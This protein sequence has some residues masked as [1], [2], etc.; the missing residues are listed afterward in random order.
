MCEDIS[1]ADDFD[2]QLGVVSGGVF[3]LIR[4]AETKPM[5][6]D[7]SRALEQCWHCSPSLAFIDP[8]RR[9]PFN[10]FVK[11]KTAAMDFLG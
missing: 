8:I 4:P 3:L 10:D 5:S 1:I 7:I 2:V 9:V 11:F 6:P